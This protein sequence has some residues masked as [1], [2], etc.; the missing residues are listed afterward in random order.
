MKAIEL[1]NQ[2]LSD[3]QIEIAYMLERKHTL[4]GMFPAIYSDSEEIVVCLDKGLMLDLAQLLKPWPLKLDKFSV[5]VNK[6]LGICFEL[7]L[8]SQRLKSTD[9]QG[10]DNELIILTLEKFNEL[11]GKKEAFRWAPGLLGHRLTPE[12]YAREITYLR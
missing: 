7:E 9:D 8:L 6:K 2:D 12:A 10:E 4:S 1:L 3:W 11:K 5:L